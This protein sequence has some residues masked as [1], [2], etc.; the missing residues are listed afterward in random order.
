MENKGN[1]SEKKFAL[2]VDEDC[3]LQDFLQKKLQGY[4]RTKIKSLITYRLLSLSDG[5][6]L[7]R[8]DTLLKKG[9]VVEVH[10]PRTH[11]GN[12]VDHPKLRIL[13]EDANIIV[14]EKKEGLLSVRAPRQ[15]EESA[16]HILNVYLRGKR[17]RG[18]HIFVVHRLDKE[19]SG[20]ML[21]AKDKETQ[22]A[23]RENWREV[24][25]ER[26]YIAVA[27][28]V[29]ENNKGCIKSYLTED[30]NQ[31]MHSSLVD[32]GG[33]YA[34]TNYK[35]LSSG[36]RYSLLRL[37]LET[38]RKNQIRVQLQSIGHPLV[39]DVKYSGPSSF[40]NRLCLHAQTLD[41]VHPVTRKRMRFEV[42]YPALFNRLLS[43]SD[44]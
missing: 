16:T 19:T 21:F 33:Q 29:F 9:Q 27:E 39:G 36:K 4:S 44:K 40:A 14:V 23:F 7:S 37:D 28:G 35:V 8:F 17:G 31:K 22:S 41:F 18:N 20:V 30:A 13:F 15:S 2:K 25:K 3:R 12:V 11:H 34:V 43:D 32:N 26:S 38:G 5:T 6:L 10:S 1:A 24:V 42:P